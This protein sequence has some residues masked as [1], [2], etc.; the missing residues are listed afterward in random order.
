MT[1][2]IELS[3]AAVQRTMIANTLCR[4]AWAYDWDELHMIGECF[5]RDAEVLFNTG[6]RKGR[7]DVVA[8]LERR[9]SVYRP[10]GDTPW[11]V[12]TNVFVRPVSSTRAIVASWYSFGVR[13]Q[14]EQLTKFTSFGW[15]DDVFILEDGDWR[16]L[17]RR[18]LRAGD[19]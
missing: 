10:D 6:L 2:P 16:V 11:H 18:V 17:T 12:S 15:Y 7:D 8:E 19:R 13:K 4:Y 14:G 9:R 3:E 1:Y 5:C